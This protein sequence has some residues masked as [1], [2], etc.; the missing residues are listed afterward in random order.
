M[1]WF[2][3]FGGLHRMIVNGPSSW[4]T[5]IKY[6]GPKQWL[7]SFPIQSSYTR[8]EGGRDEN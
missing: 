1:N 3:V 8:S 6:S 2:M 7:N 4:K 5:Y